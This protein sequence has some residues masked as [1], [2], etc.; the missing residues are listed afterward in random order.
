M[1]YAFPDSLFQ[2]LTIS[3]RQRQASANFSE[4]YGTSSTNPTTSAWKYMKLLYGNGTMPKI[5]IG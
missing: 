3:P 4:F 2:P 5:A 1:G